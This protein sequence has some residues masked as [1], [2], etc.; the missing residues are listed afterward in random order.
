MREALHKI[1]ERG[2]YPVAI[3][4]WPPSYWP[5]GTRAGSQSNL[6][7]D[8][9]EAFSRCR[10]LARTYGDLIEAWEI[11]NEPD[12][13]FTPENAETF[14]AFYKACA[15]GI[16]H[17]R[18]VHDAQKSK[19]L[20]VES[21]NV[22]NA[23]LNTDANPT[24][25]ARQSAQSKD[26]SSRNLNTFPLSHLPT[27]APAASAVMHAPLALPPGPYWDELVANDT[28]SYTE[29]FN[30]HYY[31]YAEDFRGVRDGWVD[32]LNETLD[33]RIS[34]R[35]QV[36][37][38]KSQDAE[39]GASRNA[40]LHLGPSAT[41]PDE[42]SNLSYVYR[43]PST[44]SGA[45]HHRPPLPIFLTEYGYG[46]LDR[47]DRH[48]AEGR[49]RQAE[50]HRQVLP[51]LSDGT[52]TGAM[53]FVFMP[54][55]E[56]G[57]NEFGLLAESELDP[58]YLTQSH[59]VGKV[60]E[61]Q[62]TSLD[63]TESQ[64]PPRD[65]A[66]PRLRV[67][68]IS[69]VVIDF[70]A[71]KDTQ[72][73]KRYHGH[74]LHGKKGSE[75]SGR[76][77]LV[78]YNFS[79]DPTTGLLQITVKD[80]KVTRFNSASPDVSRPD[81]P[82]VASAKGGTPQSEPDTS[83]SD[84]R[85]ST[86][87]HT[88][89]AAVPQPRPYVRPP[90]PRPSTSPIPEPNWPNENTPRFTTPNGK[91]YA[92]TPALELLRAAA[93]AYGAGVK[94]EKVKSKKLSEPQTRSDLPTSPALR[95][96]AGRDEVGPDEP[97]VVPQGGTKEDPPSDLPTFPPSH[98]LTN[99]Q[100]SPHSRTV[101]E[102]I[103]TLPGTTFTGHR[104]TATW[105]TASES[106]QQNAEGSSESPSPALRSPAGRDEV[107]PAESSEASAKEGP[108][109]Q[110]NHWS[111]DIGHWSFAPKERAILTTLLYPEPSAFQAQVLDTFTFDAAANATNREKLL[112]RP[113]ATEEAATVEKGRWLVT[114]GT[115][116]EETLFG[117]RI[118][119][120]DLPRESLRPAEVELPLP[121]GWT[122]PPDA[123]LSFQ[124]RLVPSSPSQ[125]VPPL[126]EGNP[127]SSPLRGKSLQD[128][129]STRSRAPS[130]L[131]T[132]AAGA[133]TAPNRFE[134]FDLNFRDTHGTLWSVWPRLFVKSE[135]QSYLEPARNFTPM[136][137]S[138][139]NPPH[140]LSASPDAKRRDESS[141]VPQGGTKGD[142]PPHR[143]PTTDLRSLTIMLRPRVLPTT[144]EITF[145]SIISLK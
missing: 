90:T 8:L 14:A 27:A 26:A 144:I 76:F 87:R 11:D 106:N 123:N 15:L 97:A 42:S 43:P 101:I 108:S 79:D 119:V 66:P 50:W 104:L 74:L 82:S 95:S 94:S 58:N 7:I 5:E 78:L 129:P 10:D 135:P 103:A 25:G 21:L 47:F 84:L 110:T 19:G 88:T 16:M 33:Q 92:I 6:P 83:D 105:H 126:P 120:N 128:S 113:R 138:R 13:S 4:E 55:Y 1:R 142:P 137:F 77:Q 28:L 17:G 18:A 39:N 73:V 72:A 80:G 130:H 107:G 112:N 46:L 35:S 52:I 36:S 29:A 125:F 122:L 38:S 141:F 109:D 69:P 20:K 57:V 32:A 60:A 100:L 143:L 139:A 61:P 24:I 64:S 65:F 121:D 124:Y 111:L 89:T 75:R 93:S 127:W 134:E 86:S 22:P 132:E 145:P 41:P 116:V 140:R 63:N 59:K 56:R 114:P 45:Q 2:F 70:I 12:I 51:S 81:E 96:P 23:E 31:G 117:W 102:L 62:L 54:Y 67:N 118:T 85:S 49:Q 133:A 40:E 3:L 131:H 48:T 34:Q 136:F 115:T 37:K 44:V 71:G 9:T 68:D 30:Y 98:F 53:A 99:I 91:T